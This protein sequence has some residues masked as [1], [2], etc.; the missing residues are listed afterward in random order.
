MVSFDV[1]SLFTM[2]S[3]DDSITII[4]DQLIA[5]DELEDRA[6]LS[7]DDVCELT[8]FC[9]H[10]SYFRFGD[11]FYK[12]KNGTALGSSLFPVLANIFMKNFEMTVLTTA[13]FRSKVWFCYTDNTFVIFQYPSIG[14]PSTIKWST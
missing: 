10:S 14:F 9:L 3:I 11:N 13:D 1:K 8:E 5:N 7:I 12:Q 2:V 6:I 4:R